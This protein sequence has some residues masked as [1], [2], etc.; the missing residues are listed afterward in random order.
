M[1]Q[2][3]STLRKAIVAG[4]LG[5]VSVALMFTPAGYIPWVAGASLTIMHVPAIIG[6]VMEGPWVGAIAGAI[7]GFTSLFRAATSPQGPIDTFFVNPLVSVLPRILVGL[8][9]WAVYSLFRGKARALG[10]A[11]AGVAGSITNSILVLGLLVLLKAIPLAVATTVFTANSLVE[12]VLAAVL[13]SAVVAA[14]T[15]IGA[16]AKSRLAKEEEEGQ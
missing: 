9:A 13:T 5:A 2:A 12:A 14:W 8:V 1:A 4:A 7:F 6:A 15:G 16:Q 10:A 11:A 3:S